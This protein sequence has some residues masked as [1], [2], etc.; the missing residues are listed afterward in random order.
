MC[1][2]KSVKFLVFASFQ[3]PYFYLEFGFEINVFLTTFESTLGKVN[4]LGHFAFFFARK[5]LTI[6]SKSLV[7]FVQIF[8]TTFDTYIIC[9]LL[10]SQG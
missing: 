2:F 1:K 5:L 6:S 4:Q 10:S 7:R 3:G 8:L 9:S